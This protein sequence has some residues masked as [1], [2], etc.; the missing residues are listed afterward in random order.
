MQ[1]EIIN[2]DEDSDG[3]NTITLELDEK[4]RQFLI[5]RGL[6]S[7]LQKAVDEYTLDVAESIMLNETVEYNQK[8]LEKLRLYEE[9]R[10]HERKI[11]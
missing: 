9:W 7:I 2:Y 3:G 8:Q 4:G 10:K 11:D 5:E 1:I 6:N